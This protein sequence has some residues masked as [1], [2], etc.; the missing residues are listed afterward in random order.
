MKALVVGFGSVGKKHA[1]ILAGLGL[2]VTVISQRREIPYRVYA[3]LEDVAGATRHEFAYAVVANATHHHAGALEQLI[4]LDLSRR[5]LVEKPVCATPTAFQIDPPA[6]VDIRV[7]Y[8][9]RLHPLL[10]RLA[11]E[12]GAAGGSDVSGDSGKS[13]AQSN[14]LAQA[15]CHSYLPAWRPS[16]DYRQTSSAVAGSGGVLRDLSHELDY[17]RMLFGQWTGVTGHVGNTQSL[18][19]AAEESAALVVGFERCPAATVSL[20]YCSRVEERLLTVLT[21]RHHYALD[22]TGQTLHRDGK[23]IATSH[24]TQ[25]SLIAAMHRAFLELDTQE[26]VDRQGRRERSDLCPL[27][28]GHDTVHLITAAEQA[29]ADSPWIPNR[30]HR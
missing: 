24:E 25:A 4:G 10:R 22:F 17:L 9:L 12:L 2:D 7:G 28:E 16:V 6:D 30:N 15:T 29:S 20:S 5:I 23:V 1:D 8:Q 18:G 3:D 26:H 13:P 14:I 11:D 19:I 27:A 21:D